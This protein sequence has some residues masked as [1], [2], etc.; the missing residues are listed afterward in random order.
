LRPFEQVERALSRSH[1]GAG[2]GLSYALKVVELHQ[3]GLS[4]ESAV[5]V[6]TTVRVTLPPSRLDVADEEEPST[7]TLDLA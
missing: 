1:G 5:G 4:I 2:L 3:G 7:R 6:G